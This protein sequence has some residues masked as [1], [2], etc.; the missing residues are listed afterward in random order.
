MCTSSVFSFFGFGYAGSLLLR[1]G[2][3]YCGTGALELPG[4]VVAFIRLFWLQRS[5]LVALWQVG[6]P[7][8]DQ[9][10]NLC[11]CIGRQILNNWTTREISSQMQFHG[12][13]LNLSSTPLMYYPGILELVSASSVPNFCFVAVCSVRL[14]RIPNCTW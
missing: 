5:G 6:S 12:E 13:S 2:F 11:P 10:W 9:E 1:S 3:S 4:S 8:L 14:A 7:F